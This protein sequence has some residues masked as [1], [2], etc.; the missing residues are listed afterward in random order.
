M[1][2]SPLSSE[3]HSVVV[4]GKAEAMVDALKRGINEQ[5]IP[6]AAIIWG[7]PN[8]FLLDRAV[9]Y[10]EVVPTR[11]E[12]QNSTIY[13]IASLT[14]V[15]ATWPLVAQ[16]LQSGA[17]QLTQTVGDLI[18]ESAQAPAAPIT[19]QQ[20]L[21][22]TSGLM[23]ATWL[24]QYPRNAA[25][26]RERLV[27]EKLEWI[28]GSRV[29]Y[30]N[31]PFIL[32]GFILEQVLGMPLERACK[33]YVWKPLDMPDTTFNPDGSVL[34]R[35]ASTEER[36]GTCLKGSVHDESAAWLGGVAGHAGAFSTTRDLSRFASAVLT[37]SAVVGGHEV[38]ALTFTDHT[39]QL[40]VSRGLA[41]ESYEDWNPSGNV[42]GHL[43]FTGTSLWLDFGRNEYLVLLSNRVHP[44]RGDPQAM[45]ALRQEVFSKWQETP[46]Q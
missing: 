15:V 29:S 17:L 40:G 24:S 20:L 8:R 32:L 11:V 31:R 44:K 39:K 5:V 9:G 18:P 21:T 13:D 4:E 36:D 12:A 41:W 19:I 46:L 22:H 6:G 3:S 16:A 1:H 14:K 26:I 42:W 37:R 34:A 2:I 28:P 43:G 23:Q 25:T 30:S 7:S 45:R 27:N 35:I 38:S 33:E 10:A